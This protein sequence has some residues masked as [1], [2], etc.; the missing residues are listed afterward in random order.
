MFSHVESRLNGKK[1]NDKSV[2]WTGTK[3]RGEAE[4]KE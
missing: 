3:M 1:M 4:N 2:K